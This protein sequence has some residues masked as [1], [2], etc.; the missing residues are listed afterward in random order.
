MFNVTGDGMTVPTEAPTMVGVSAIAG[1]R[2]WLDG[3][4]LHPET[5]LYARDRFGLDADALRELDIKGFDPD[6]DESGYTPVGRSFGSFPRMVVPFHGFDGVARGVQGRDLSGKCP[7]RWVG[8]KNPT[9]SRWALYGVFPGSGGYGATIITEGPSDALTAVA[10]GYDAVA[11][12]G[13]SLAASP[14]LVQE[15]ADGL[16][17]TQVIVAGDADTAGTT[18][19]ERLAAG[20][21]GHGI[22]VYALAIPAGVGDLNDWRNRNADAFPAELHRAVSA[23][24]VPRAAAELSESREI[25][26]RTGTDSVT[27]DE[28]MEA[29]RILAGLMARFGE[30]DA[31]NA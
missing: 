17:G 16:R 21:A 25:S 10:V 24:K 18:F 6:T 3:L 15:L 20:L 22:E 2:V 30:S 7:G 13:A 12:R 8:L 14:E 26:N 31:M 28:G 9:G 19:T 5:V 27:R 23:A 11:V 1:L 4:S 29:A